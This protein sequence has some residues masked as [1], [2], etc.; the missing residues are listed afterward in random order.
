[1]LKLHQHIIVASLCL[2]AINSFSQSAPAQIAV[3]AVLGNKVM[4][5]IDGK[6]YI[7]TKKQQK[8]G[9]TLLDFDNN[10]VKLAIDGRSVRLHI[11][12]AP[13]QT[14][15]AP[16]ARAE[17]ILYPDQHG[18]FR[19]HGSINGNA[20]AFLVDTGATTVALSAVTAQKLGIDYQKLA[21]GKKVS[22]STA[23]GIVGAYPIVLDTVSIG[24][25]SA[26][27]VRALVLDGAGNEVL[28]GMSFLKHLKVQ[29][30][31]GVLKLSNSY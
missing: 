1:M 3:A 2:Y 20:T 26:A 13:L 21:A 16:K 18:M 23:N 9:V 27:M 29:H 22:V 17:T 19:G 4:L 14:H 24:K 10:S 28:L 15:Y 11:G 7:F 31:Q 12:E 30:S 5:N 25:V 8:A 6:K